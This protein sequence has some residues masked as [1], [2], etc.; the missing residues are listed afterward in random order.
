[1]DTK[2]KFW[3][4]VEDRGT[5]CAAVHGSTE[6]RRRLSNWTTITII[7]QLNHSECKIAWILNPSFALWWAVSFWASQRIFCSLKILA[8]MTDHLLTGRPTCLPVNTVNAG[9]GQM[10]IIHAEWCSKGPVSVRSLPS[11]SDSVV[12][13]CSYQEGQ[14]WNVSLSLVP[15]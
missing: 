15:L 6:S 2:S 13:H 8:T 7:E 9:P 4:V 11:L 14:N 12:C 10:R 3:E 1:M 5:R